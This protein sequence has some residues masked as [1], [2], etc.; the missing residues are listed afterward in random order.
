MKIKVVQISNLESL[1]SFWYVHLCGLD[2]ICSKG[3]ISKELYI[4]GLVSGLDQQFVRY[5]L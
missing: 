4:V 1:I 3:L 5:K 2:E